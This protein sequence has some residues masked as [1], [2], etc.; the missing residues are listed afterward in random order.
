MARLAVPLVDGVANP[1][2]E[3]P[4][5]AECAAADGLPNDDAEPGFDLVDPGKIRLG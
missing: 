5:R 2:D 4:D 3:N 1:L